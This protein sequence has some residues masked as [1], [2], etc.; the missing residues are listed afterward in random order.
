M[1]KLYL[2]LILSIFIFSIDTFAQQEKGLFIKR[3][4]LKS[5]VAINSEDVVLD[6]QQNVLVANAFGVDHFNGVKWKRYRISED[7]TKIPRYIILIKNI[8]EANSFILGG[9][10]K[11]GILR[12]QKGT[13]TMEAIVNTQETKE[14]LGGY[15]YKVIQNNQKT[16]FL[17][18]SSAVIVYD[19]HT[20]QK[21][22]IPKISLKTRPYYIFWK[23]KIFLIN[24]SEVFT[25]NKTSWEKTNGL[26]LL[27][28]YA[29]QCILKIDN[30]VNL[31]IA[32]N[33]GAYFWKGENTFTR[34]EAIS[35]KL[36]GSFFTRVK[37]QNDNLYI[38][39]NN[40][41]LVY[42]LKTKQLLFYKHFKQT[43]LNGFTLDKQGNTWLGTTEG[44]FFVETS[45]PFAE[46]I[47]TT[48]AKK[49]LY[50]KGRIFEIQKDS[51]GVII[52]KGQKQQ[53]FNDI[54]FIYKI[55]IQNDQNF[56]C[57]Q[58]GT[59]TFDQESNALKE[60][61]SGS[62]FNV[63]YQNKEY[64][65]LGNNSLK[66]LNKSFRLKKKLNISPIRY[67]S[68]SILYKNNLFYSESGSVFRLDLSKTSDSTANKTQVKFPRKT[69][70]SFSFQ[71]VQEK[72]MVVNAY[73]IF[74]LNP[75]QNFKV[76]EVTQDIVNL[77]K[78]HVGN[79]NVYF[80]LAKFLQTNKIL[81]SPVYIG[82]N[83]GKNLPLI[84][85]KN[86]QGQWQA[87]R[88]PFRRLGKTLASDLVKN[89]KGNYE[90]ITKDHIIEYNPKRKFN[91]GYAFKSYI[92]EVLVKTIKADT[93]DKEQIRISVVDSAIYA[94]HTHTSIPTKLNYQHNTLTF[95][96]A[97]DSWAAYERNEYS[98]QLVG[99]D[100]TWSN[101][102]KEQKKEYT[103]LREGTYTFQVRCRNV[104]G[105]ISSV[106]TYTFTILP[107]WYRTWW[108]YGLYL[109]V[110]VSL[111]VA[112]SMG[113]TRYRSRQL[114]KRNQELEQT[115]ALRTEEIRGQKAE[116][117]QQAAQLKVSN[118]SLNTANTQLQV[119]AEELKTTNEALQNTNQELQTINE[120]LEEAN[121]QIKKEQEDRLKHYV[122]RV[123]ESNERF[124]EVIKI[125]K[126]SGLEA[127]LRFLENE[128][129]TAGKMAS[130]QAEVR[131][132]YPEFIAKLDQGLLAEDIT[133]TQWK[134]GQCL[135]LGKSAS[136]ISA[137][138][139]IKT[140][141]IYSYGSR[142]RKAGLL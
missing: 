102:S 23:N 50:H 38:C 51:R 105:T 41:L 11:C 34:I 36:K 87:N 14:I 21:Q 75:S 32:N 8:Y 24:G 106:V 1:T 46:R 56:I 37:K 120:A 66:I 84:L 93:N 107:P 115:V 72:L 60:V 78:D 19:H 101:W 91:T 140:S 31:V 20:K 42:N 85:Q 53:K 112:G 28:K 127:G 130:I 137:L 119:T 67:T 103:N 82:I 109:L 5:G 125:L 13:F 61:D 64:Y 117:T 49:R 73:G 133:Y 52:R 89:P 100:D 6:N 116:I 126:T 9:G 18:R 139:D 47:N 35:K 44:V 77:P 110:G 83:N 74:E 59:Y 25:L 3:Y 65:L 96:Y 58:K 30:Q 79:Y 97:S 90:F 123:S 121:A 12:K 45:L 54:G 10:G 113:Y 114:R 136:E 129:N 57:T 124:V 141:S 132:A 99:Q 15:L 55:T 68:H 40:K 62:C 76:Q 43:F 92:R 81:T 29:P 138:L 48:Q 98:Y 128:V 27:K 63:F 69:F 104:Y 70:S 131:K 22:K 80:S 95:T 142:M 4:A 26:S 111:V 134:V 88:K 122:Q 86:E 135:K 39:S 33:G 108:A 71:V 17:G 94:S 16:Y 2:I 118:E 7:Y